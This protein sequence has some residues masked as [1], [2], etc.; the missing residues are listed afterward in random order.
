VA[1]YLVDLY[2]YVASV[3]RA[4]HEMQRTLKERLYALRA[5]NDPLIRTRVERALA[6]I[7]AGNAGEGA[8]TASELSSLLERYA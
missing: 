5:A 6:E 8:V 4:I 7:E 3:D 1:E 2:G